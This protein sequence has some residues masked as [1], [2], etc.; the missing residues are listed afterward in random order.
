MLTRI[1]GALA[2]RRTELRDKEGGFT[3][4]ELLVVV[5]IIGIL[6]AIAIPVYLGIQDNAKDGAVKSDLANA[7]IAVVAY[8]AANPSATS[9]TLGDT[10]KSYGYTKSDNTSTLVFGT[11]PTGPG[12]PFCITGTGTTTH[13][14]KISDAAG[15]SDG[16]CS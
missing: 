6:A 12:T 8:F 2:R 3:L 14:F 10:L 15:V 7:K 13:Q 16:A 9:V 4:V 5:L 1:M 11:S